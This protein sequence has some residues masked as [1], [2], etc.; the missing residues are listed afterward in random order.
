MEETFE[1]AFQCKAGGKFSHDDT[2]DQSEAAKALLKHAR[3]T[4]LYTRI[5][6]A[7]LGLTEVKDTFVGDTNVRG[8]SGGQR[9]R[10]TVGEMLMPGC[11]VVCGDEISTG[12]D[13]AS[14]FDM[15]Q[16]VLHFGRMANLT[17]I[18]SLL[19]P[20]PETVSLFD[21]LILLGEGQVI[22]CGPVT[23]VE[24][25]FASIGYKAPDFM[26]S[27]DF[28]QLI[29]TEEG[30]SLYK[31]DDDQQASRPD[32][33]T[34]NELAQIFRDS[35]CGAR[36]KYMLATPP[37]YIWKKGADTGGSVVDP[38]RI[39]SFTKQYANSFVRSTVLITQRFVKLWIRD[40]RVVVVGAL[41]NVVMGI[42]VGGV[43][44]NTKDPI[45]IQ[46]ALFQA[47][48]FVMLGMLAIS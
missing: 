44:F 42:S 26:D 18:I 21:E 46:G 33:P 40:M 27:A 20:S 30:A 16:L 14:T 4:K 32:A 25:Y 10:V 37:S 43:F 12:L 3:E 22:Y 34:L 39:E 15:I 41:K 48:L 7:S 2:C 47:G 31:P 19:Q 29:C 6:L 23:D 9:R 36:I 11:P 17:R 28:L 1:F 35:E 13:S 5:L 38:N 8:V 24:N 45:S